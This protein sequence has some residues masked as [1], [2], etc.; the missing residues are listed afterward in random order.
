[1]S[2]ETTRIA[3]APEN[4]VTVM[5]AAGTGKTWLLITRL[6]RLLLASGRLGQRRLYPASL[7]TRMENPA[8]TT[9]E[10]HEFIFL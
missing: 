3:S 9:G 4:N 2:T 10:T 5:A 1:M 6:V 7:I 8:T